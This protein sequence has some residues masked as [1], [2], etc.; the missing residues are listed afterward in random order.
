MVFALCFLSC[1]IRFRKNILCSVLCPLSSVF[2][3]LSSVFR[4]PSSVL[5]LPSSVFRPLI[6]DLRL[7]IS[8]LRY[9]FPNPGTRSMSSSLRSPMLARDTRSR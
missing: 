1:G 6:S 9:P 3:L 8:D 7:P 2:C 5:R 4:L